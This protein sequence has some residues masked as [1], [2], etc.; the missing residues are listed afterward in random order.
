LFP[1][2]PQFDTTMND[3]IPLMMLMIIMNRMIEFGFRDTG[4]TEKHVTV[5]KGFGCLAIGNGDRINKKI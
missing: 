4:S 2:L 5:G 3:L 1:L